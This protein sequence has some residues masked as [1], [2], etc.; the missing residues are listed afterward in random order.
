MCFAYAFVCSG[1]APRAASSVA[2]AQPA[3]SP[4]RATAS[5]VRSEAIPDPTLDPLG[6]LAR[7]LAACAPLR[8]Y[9][10]TLT[11]QERRGLGPFV[12]LQPPEEIRCR[13][14]REPFSVY[15]EWTDP[16]VKYGVSTYVAGQQNDKV[17]FTPRVWLFG[18]KPDV[19]RVSLNTPVIWGEARH[20]VSEFGLEKL[21]QQ[22]F[23]HLERAAG[24]ATVTYRGL[25]PRPGARSTP[26]HHFRIVYPQSQ[27][28]SPVQELWIDPESL[29]P[30]GTESRFLDGSLDASYHYADLRSDVTLTD[31]DFL[32]PNEREAF[33]EADAG[34]P[35][36]SSASVGGQV[37]P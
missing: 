36:E 14:R 21:M 17:R 12:R 18:L 13:F 20:P 23:G 22:T 24:A 29:L 5:P 26:A 10:V 27:H 32:L 7:S 2:T 1:C 31:E 35:N 37:T 28:P 8:Q 19:V 15:F 33:D 3:S 4:A 16:N 6:F 9:E 30:V 11:R 25:E 34:E